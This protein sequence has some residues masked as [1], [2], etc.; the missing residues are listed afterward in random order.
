M[1]TN[2][3]YVGF[4]SVVQWR[5]IIPILNYMGGLNVNYAATLRN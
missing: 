1:T 3:S 2:A 4:V 5:F